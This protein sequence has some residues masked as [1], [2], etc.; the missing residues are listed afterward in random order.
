MLN[1]P[2]KEGGPQSLRLK[3]ITVEVFQAFYYWLNSGVVDCAGDSTFPS[4]STTQLWKKIIE[5][6]IFTDCHQ[7]RAFQ[8]AILGHL[9][10]ANEDTRKLAMHSRPF[11]TPTRLREIR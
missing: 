5:V 8:N 11:F 3:D 6:Y 2:F 1:G 9:Y 10:L 7:A 4:L